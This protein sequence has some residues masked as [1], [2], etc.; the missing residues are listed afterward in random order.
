MRAASERPDKNLLRPLVRTV[1]QEVLEAE[2]TDALGP[3]LPRSRALTA[4]AIDTS[5]CQ[6]P[7]RCGL[8]QRDYFE[9]WLIGTSMIALM[10][11]LSEASVSPRPTPKLNTSGFMST[12]M[13]A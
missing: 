10:V 8:G 3:L 7:I 2:M 5:S 9:S 11:H 1:L 13:V 4:K 12:S 6:V